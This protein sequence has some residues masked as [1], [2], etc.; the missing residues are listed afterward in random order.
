MPTTRPPVNSRLRLNSLE[1]VRVLFR[2]VVRVKIGV[3]VR[4]VFRVRA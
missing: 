1:L 4:V 2:V 3:R